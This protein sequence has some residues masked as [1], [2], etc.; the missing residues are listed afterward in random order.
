MGNDRGAGRKAKLNNEQISDIIERKNNGESITKLALEHGLSRQALYKCINRT[1]NKNELKIDYVVNGSVYMTLLVDV[2]NKSVSMIQ[3]ADRVL[4]YGF[5]LDKNHSWECLR[6][7]LENQYLKS[8]GY[9]DMADTRQYICFDYSKSR[10]NLS[11]VVKNYPNSEKQLDI[12]RSKGDKSDD[13][14]KSNK[15]KDGF[16]WAIDNEQKGE[17]PCFEFAKNDLLT[18]RT[19]TDGFQPKAISK[20]GKWFI[21]SQAIIGGARMNDWLV[22]I[23]ASD[24][25]MQLEIPCVLQKRCEFLYAGHS[26]DAVYSKNFEVE[27]CSFVSFERLLERAGG[28]MHDDEFIRMSPVEKLKWCAEKLSKA[29]NISYEETERYMVNLALIDCLVGNVDR[30]GRNFGLFYNSHTESYEIPMLFDN[31]MG[32]FEHDYYRDEYK[33]F[34]E[35]MRNVYISPY[36]VDPFDML[37]ILDDEFDLNKTYPKLRNLQIKTDNISE[38]A[39]EY[40]NR[41]MTIIKGI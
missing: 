32:L 11:D 33:T 22:E 4:A 25:C 3:A 36:G 17:M 5:L 13:R 24:V 12:D 14:I 28:S 8:L 20:D 23:I 34:D 41:M 31:G 39:K 6:D 2:D 35:A 26:F 9:D 16:Y 30:H 1:I 27:A 19:D 40:I 29:G 37:K 18:V 21:K 38:F 7:M 15:I 10:F